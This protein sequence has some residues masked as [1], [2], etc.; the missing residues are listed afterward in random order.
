METTRIVA[1]TQTSRKF[2]ETYFITS[3]TKRK[4]K[5][6]EITETKSFPRKMHILLWGFLVLALIELNMAASSDKV[7]NDGREA[8]KSQLDM[9]LAKLQRQQD[10]QK[11]EQQLMNE[12]IREEQLMNEVLRDQIQEQKHKNDE[13]EREIKQQRRKNDKQ[14][15]EIKEQRHNNN[16]LQEESKELTKINRARRSEN[17]TQHLLELIRAEINHVAGLSQCEV[18]T[19]LASGNVKRTISSERN[20]TRTPKVVTS[21]FGFYRERDGTYHSNWGGYAEPQSITTTKFDLQF[22]GYAIY[23]IKASWIACI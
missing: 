4:R 21:I 9:I 20:F 18:G 6:N 7:K 10:E 16:K 2:N 5:R 22:F 1:T 11:K 3:G 8:N 15:R 12:V 13:Q 14:E 23:H 19:S 17:E